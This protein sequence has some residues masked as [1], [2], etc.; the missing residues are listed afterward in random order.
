MSH[1]LSISTPSTNVTE[2]NA[3]PYT[4]PDGS[5]ATYPTLPTL[6]PDTVNYQAYTATQVNPLIDEC[7]YAPAYQW[8]PRTVNVEITKPGPYWLTFSATNGT[9][10][11]SHTGDG[12][13]PAIDN[14]ILTALGSPYMS[15]PP[16]TA[17][18]VIPTPTPAH[19]TAYYGLNNAYNGFYIIA[20][21]FAPPA[22]DQ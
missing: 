6:A 5:S 17:L 22:A 1:G 12:A 2:G 4:N 15:S 9:G 8:V 3:T 16:T 11:S 7:S 19:D 14:V 20:D 18:T 13:G 10:D 21:P